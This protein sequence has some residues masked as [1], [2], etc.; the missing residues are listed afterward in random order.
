M[1]RDSVIQVTLAEAVNTFVRDVHTR[2]LSPRTERFYRSELDHF[3]KWVE[4]EGVSTLGAVTA[5]LIRKYLLD[6]AERRNEGGVHCAYR[7]IKAMMMFWARET[8]GD[9]TPAIRKVKVKRPP[10]DPLEPI[11]KDDF[12]KL[13]G[14]CGKD[15]HGL[16]D[17]AILR[18]LLDTGVRA[19][20]LCGFDLADLNLA[21][22]SLL[23]RRGKGRKTRMVFFGKATRRA[24]RKWLGQRGDDKGGA[25][26]YPGGR[27]D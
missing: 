26:L 24:L 6:L 8:D 23:V 14:A 21:D 20:E 17:G 25:V 27:P 18:V 1:Q 7:S 5:D 4:G 13:L 11:A 10:T 19:S 12:E 15:F 22:A 9:Y 16:R 2:Q 3:C